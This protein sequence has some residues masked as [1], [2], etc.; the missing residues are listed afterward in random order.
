MST[1]G[2]AVRAV[3]SDDGAVFECATTSS[4]ARTSVGMVVV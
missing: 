1:E 2:W 4:S 3:L